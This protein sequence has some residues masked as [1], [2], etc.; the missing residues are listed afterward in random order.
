[1]RALTSLVLVAL[2]TA[3]AT[4]A[5]RAAQME[6]EIDEMIQVY[7]PA[8]E[9]LGFQRDS[10]PWRDC[11]LRLAAKDSFERYGRAPTTT[12]CFGRRGF[13]QCTRF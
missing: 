11:V 6:L 5:E 8:C 12:S 10:D 3:C 13:Y 1:M 9:R 2:L 7:G 4:P